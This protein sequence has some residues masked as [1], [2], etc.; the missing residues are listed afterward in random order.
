MGFKFT[1]QVGD[2]LRSLPDNSKKALKTKL[3]KAFET[4]VHKESVQEL[5]SEL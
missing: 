4:H 1:L 5:L 3:Q 2:C